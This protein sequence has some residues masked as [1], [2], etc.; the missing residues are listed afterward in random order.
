MENKVTL[1]HLR[2]LAYE[3]KHGFFEPMVVVCEGNVPDVVID[4]LE[5]Y[6]IYTMKK[7]QDE[8]VMKHA[9]SYLE[10][11]GYVVLTALH[12]HEVDYSGYER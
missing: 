2:N 12:T 3:E 7:P 6:L 1:I 9:Q 4:N 11:Y 10:A 5:E 8:S